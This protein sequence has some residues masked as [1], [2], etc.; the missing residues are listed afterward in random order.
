MSKTQRTRQTV[1]S[2]I[3]IDK[4]LARRKARD[5]LYFFTKI[6]WHLIEPGRDFIDGWHIKAI[7]DHLE[8][9]G[10]FD[11]KKLIINMPPRHM[12][13]IL[14]CV[15]FPAW[16]WG[17]HPERSFIYG[18]HDASL[19]TRDS[20]KTRNLIISEEYQK[21]FKP[22]WTLADDENQK[23]QFQNTKGGVRKSVGVGSGIM[24]HGA[25][26]LFIDDP[27]NAFDAES[28]AAR[29]SVNLWHDTVLSTRYNDADRH[30][31]VIIMQRLDDVVGPGVV[32][33]INQGS[34]RGGFPMAGRAGNQ[35]KTL[36]CSGKL[37]EHGR[38]IKFF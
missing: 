24:G 27:M 8:A 6:M 25:D 21:I 14:A 28:E 33:F 34:E 5:S 31:K 9:V 26:Y 38:K 30:A 15:A 10:R 36:V 1:I 19:A 18:S 23:K 2:E 29:Y 13:S 3:E 22:D 35:H 12:K 4:E 32:N 37:M 7:C 16:I 20:V 17:K 11:I